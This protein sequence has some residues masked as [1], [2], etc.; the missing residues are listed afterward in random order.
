VEET[1]GQTPRRKTLSAFELSAVDFFD[2]FAVYYDPDDRC[3]AI[4]LS[5]LGPRAAYDGY[6]LFAH[7]AVEDRAWA[8]ARD[9]D[10]E[11]TDG[12]VSRTLGLSMYAPEIDEPDLDDEEQAMPAQCFLVFRPGYWEAERARLGIAET[13]PKR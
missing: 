11:D 10:M 8:R 4:E 5:R 9:P 7:P 3:W 2:A 13:P 6:Q 12:F 1:V